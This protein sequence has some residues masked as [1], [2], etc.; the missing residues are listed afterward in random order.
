MPNH[1]PIPPEL[2]HLIE[3]RET[4]DRRKEERRSGPERRACDLGP[5]GTVESL[6]D[7]PQPPATD[8]RS[9]QLQRQTRD[10]RNKARRKSDV[11]P[12]LP[13]PPE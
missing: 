12:Q 5:I 7:A 8:R 9:N 13:D 11:K 10:R 6:E 4:D 3:K 1:L 2:Q